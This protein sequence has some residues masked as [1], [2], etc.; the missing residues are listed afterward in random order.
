MG[1]GQIVLVDAMDRQLDDLLRGGACEVSH[2]AAH[3]LHGVDAD[4]AIV[5]V[6]R[7]QRLPE[8]VAT[9]RRLRPDASVIIVARSLD[10]ALM[11]DAMRV[12]VNECLVEPLSRTALEDAIGRIRMRAGAASRGRIV[13][14]AG[15]KG[16]VGTTTIAVN[17]ATALAQAAYGSTLLIDLRACGGDAALLLGAEPQF[18]T[19]DVLQNI[20]RLDETFLKGA[21]ARTEAGLDLLASAA[22]PGP[23]ELDPG[24]VKVL[25]DFVQAR[26]ACVVLDL[27]AHQMALMD[28]LA[29]DAEIF[30]VATQELGAIRNA[31]AIAALLRQHRARDLVRLAVNR[32]AEAADFDIATIEEVTGATVRLTVPGDYK[33][34]IQALNAGRPLVLEPGDAVA[35][36]IRALARTLT[37]LTSAAAPPPPGRPPTLFGRLASRLTASLGAQ[38]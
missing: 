6:R 7:D 22:R 37:G 3:E 23:A 13:A 16:G 25:L 18:S 2:R 10:T 35:Q 15:A 24:A 38:S 33:A 5:D 31:T 21:V 32:F 12:G 14:F 1:A 28:A 17:V 4:V 29:T 9:F 11:L 8:A 36:P 30:L 20:N 34:A 26:Y 27:P 19:L